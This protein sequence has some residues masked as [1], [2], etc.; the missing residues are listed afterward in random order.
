MTRLLRIEYGAAY[1]H[2]MIWCQIW[3]YVAAPR[4]ILLHGGMENLSRGFLLIG[5][6]LIIGTYQVGSGRFRLAGQLI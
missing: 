3:S 6:G 5:S 4:Q 2:V 1:Y